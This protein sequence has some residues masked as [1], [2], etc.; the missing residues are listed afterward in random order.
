MFNKKYEF[1]AIIKA[2]DMGGAF[3][4][5]PFDTFK[6]FGIKGRVKINATFDGVPYRGSMVKMKSDC[7]LLLI[8][9]DIRKLINK[10]V[11]NVIKVTVELD[12][13]IREVVIPE[14]L[15]AAFEKAEVAFKNFKKLSYTHQREYVNW[16]NQAKKPETRL[17]RIT[18]TIEMLELGKT[19]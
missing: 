16:I 12:T 18:K 10:D 1:D 13:D 7:H 9:K 3:V 4:E 19:V 6:E 11:G 5:F 15:S 14:D 8:L 17:M 2:G